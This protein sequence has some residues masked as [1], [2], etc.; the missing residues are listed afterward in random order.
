MKRALAYMTLLLAVAI[1]STSCKIKSAST[2]TVPGTFTITSAAAGDSEVVLTW[3]AA[4]GA[5]SYTVEYGT[6]SGS[7]ATTFSTNATSPTTVTGLTNGTTYYFMVLAI[8][9]GGTV[10]A[11]SE[12]SATPGTAPGAFTLSSATAGIGQVVL[13]WGASSGAASYTV[14]YGTSSETFSTTFS[15]SAAS[16]TTVTGLTYGT[17]YYFMVTAVNPI[18]STNATA[19]ISGSPLGGMNCYSGFI[20][21]DSGYFIF[22]SPSTN[23][24]ISYLSSIP[25][26]QITNIQFPLFVQ[27]PNNGNINGTAYEGTITLDVYACVTPG[28]APSTGTLVGSAPATYS[29]EIGSNFSLSTIGTGTAGGLTQFSFASSPITIPTDC[30]AGQVPLAL[31]FT[32][33]SGFS[34]LEILAPAMLEQSFPNCFLGVSGSSTTVTTGAENSFQA[35]ITAQ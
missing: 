3:T 26:T 24:P 7:Y 1:N 13:S 27:A 21:D 23:N 14:A 12:I 10:N 8:E 17:T 30:S 15:T 29:G 2:T 25:G 33:L 19:E 32:N 16:P 6:A 35:I 31:E 9:S 22:R 5:S 4:T 28:S 18:G 34:D 20:P 11:A